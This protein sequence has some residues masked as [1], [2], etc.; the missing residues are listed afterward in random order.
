MNDNMPEREAHQELEELLPWYANG[1]LDSDDRV[2]VE[3]HL[4]SCSSCREELALDRRLIDEFQSLT[5]EIDAGWARMRA[6]IA[7]TRK[8]A[9]RVPRMF[10]DFWTQLRQP[11]VA[12][13]A[14][15]QVAFVI[16][17][18][19]V[20]LTLSRPTY[21]ALGSSQAPQTANVLVIFRADATVEEVHDTL[22]AANASVVGGPTATDAYLL[23]VAPNRRD[24][25][26][27]KLQS[28]EDVELAQPIDGP[29]R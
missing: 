28:D 18:A 12:A 19:G 9:P 21:H 26:L 25:A 23:S 3:R 16:F 6:R 20:L 8:P 7:P 22:Q 14:A 13:L 11:G 1:R 24:Q 27:R 17:G 4:E 29:G 10:G 5:P 2:K 15:A